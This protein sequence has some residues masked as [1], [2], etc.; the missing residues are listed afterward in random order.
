MFVRALVALL[1][2]AGP[3][4][5]A[6]RALDEVEPNE[7][8]QTANAVAWPDVANGERSSTADV[9]SFRFTG[10]EPGAP[11]VASLDAPF[12][13]LGWFAN[14]GS[15]LDSV[16][17][18]GVLELDV[19]ADGMGQAVLRVCGH[20]SVGAFDCTPSSLGAGGYTLALPEPGAGV[21]AAAAVLALARL[22]RGGERLR[23][24]RPRF[25]APS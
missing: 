14:D 5:G 16:A 2:L 6:A 21:L 9:D 10:L 19:E 22:A 13:G 8:I 1:T 15:L 3:L 7:T 25:R 23:P 24:R 12:L 11:Y 18:E 20:S 4:A 17:F